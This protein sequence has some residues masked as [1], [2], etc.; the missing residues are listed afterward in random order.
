MVSR[1]VKCD[2]CRSECVENDKIVNIWWHYPSDEELYLLGMPAMLALI[3]KELHSGLNWYI[4]SKN[5]SLLP[6]NQ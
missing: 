4:H 1:H 2:C 5:V 6:K 3:M